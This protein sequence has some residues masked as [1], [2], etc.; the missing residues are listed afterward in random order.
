MRTFWQDLRYGARMLLKNPSFTLIAVLTL[1]L[2]IGANTAIFS[3]VNGVLLKPLPYREP[4]RLIRVFERSRTQPKFPMSGG[5]FQD[6]R[7]QN[8][9]LSGLALYTRQDLELSQDDKPER[10]AALRVSAGFFE[11]LG[12]Q[13]LL[14]REFRR[15]DELP[16]NNQVVI[17][18]HGLW[19]RRFNGDPNVVG[20]VVTLSGQP[21]TVVGVAPQGLQHVGGD[22]RSMP[23][24][25]SVDAWWPVALRP[26]AGRG[27]H[28]LNAVGSLKPGVSV[29]QAEA[30]FNVIAERLAQQFPNSNQGWRIAI[31]PLREEIAGRART[32]LLALFGAVFFVL[33]I[34]CVNVA[35]LLLARATAREREIAVR[36]AVGAGRRRIVRQ[37]LTESLLLAVVGGAA[38]ILL[39][40]W[41]IDTLRALGPEQL[42]RL[43]AVNIDGGILLFT[44]GV[45]LLTGVLFGLAPALQAGQFNL[46]AFLKEGGRGGGGQRRRLRDALVITEVA[47]ALALLAGAGLLI[48][49]FW[50]LQQTDPGFNPE[51]VLTASL[52]LPGARYGDA[53]K[54]AAFQ[55]LLLER[56]AALPGAQSAGLTSDLPWTGYDENAGFTVE[57]KTFPPND[58][59]SARYHFV[60]SDYFRTIGV[61]L[62][63]GRFFNSDDRQ[64]TQPV[65][66]INRAM[67][68]R[69]W[70]GASAVGKR[71]TFSSQPNERDWFTVVGVV[72]DVKDFP[73]SLAAAPAFYWA[74]MQQTPRQIIL[75][76]R[77]SADPLNL[78]EAVRNEV[79]ALDKDLPL[80]DAQTLE[81]IAATAVA[82]RRFTLWLVGFFALTA[83]ALAAI[84]I[85]SVLSYLVAQRTHEIG[86]RMALGAQLGDV[87]KLVV[88]QGM[89]PVLTGLAMGII[90][91]IALTRLIKGLLFEVSATDPLAFAMAAALLALVSLLACYVP[92]R[93]ATKVDPMVALKYE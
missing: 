44:L 86:L 14:G 72:G 8:S 34:A 1:A 79:R 19:Q 92:A 12:A 67:A 33:L 23:H 5:N 30:D 26:Q 32:T 65:V 87:L 75:A 27:A 84:G 74:T 66:L 31:Q 13:P 56:L 58:G 59:P 20:R 25:E 52:S 51:R 43:Q 81:T 62:I 78:V 83:M 91:A 42:P 49:S 53:P 80:A 61:P 48:R 36:S 40:Q 15:E 28:F 85:Y 29:A 46:N 35:N 21:F 88:R 93:R 60:S 89:T 70:P 22:Y 24:G 39:A 38:G 63:A 41:A 90:A 82:G 17:L 9:T 2:G 54:V 18:S 55:Q 57:G 47:L 37:L 68:E 50:K 76:V 77:S 64:D 3:V 45:T 11:L 69:Y 16:D 10:L 6:Y 73:H 4:E 71:F 7:D